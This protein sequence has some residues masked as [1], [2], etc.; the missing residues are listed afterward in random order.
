[1]H[2]QTLMIGVLRTNVANG[3]IPNADTQEQDETA[4]LRPL[5]FVHRKPPA[6]LGVPESFQLWA[7]Y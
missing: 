2:V 6:R 3:H 7:S 5:F 4:F 1:M